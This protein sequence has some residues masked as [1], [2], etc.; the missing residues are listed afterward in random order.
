M[1]QTPTR[2]YG[3]LLALKPPLMPDGVEIWV[4]S[5]GGQGTSLESTQA[6]LPL[7]TSTRLE[8]RLPLTGE[9]MQLPG[10]RQTDTGADA[11]HH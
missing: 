11:S 4:C 1:P 5:S 6:L 3:P 8:G 9:A 10:S 7:A 2:Q